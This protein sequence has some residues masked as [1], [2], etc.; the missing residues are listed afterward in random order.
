MK[1][2]TTPK[3]LKADIN[4]YKKTGQTI[5]FVPTMGYLHEGH[6]S[7]IQTARE[8]ADI[9]VVSVFVNPTQFGPNEDFDTYPRDLE[10]DARL[11]QDAGADLLFHPEV[12]DIYS[13]QDN[14]DIH[15]TKRV[16]TLCGR[17]RP[18]HFDGVATVLTKLFHLVQPDYVFFGKKDAQ[19]VA[20]VDGLIHTFHFPIKLIACE[21]VREPDG[22]AKSSRNVRL[23]P[24]ERAEAVYLNKAL[25]VGA[26]AIEQGERNSGTIENRVRDYLNRHLQLGTIDYV[27]VL[28]Y[29]DCEPIDRLNGQVIIAVAVHFPHAR[30]I[31]NRIVMVC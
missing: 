30:L 14:I 25:T 18:G 7:L 6:L 17:S 3:D 28:A 21:T 2:I 15:V 26:D 5:G 27:E 20:V 8:T 4:A 16:H 12:G 29:P 23:S 10:R 22:L 11:A 19:Q 1:V 24:E 13:D 9:V 31:D